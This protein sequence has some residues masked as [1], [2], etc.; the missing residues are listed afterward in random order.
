MSGKERARGCVRF[1]W[2]KILA[3][4][5][6]TARWME[7]VVVFPSWTVFA[8]LLLALSPAFWRVPGLE[9]VGRAFKGLF[10]VV[11]VLVVSVVSAA[12]VWH[13]SVECVFCLREDVVF[14]PPLHALYFDGGGL[15]L[16]FRCGVLVV[17]CNLYMFL[18][19]LASGFSGFGSRALLGHGS[20]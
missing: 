15:A 9:A 7:W 11:L 12:C 8:V 4:T 5:M 6:R 3:T 17:S 10:G 18:C 16:G 2:T 20:M 19:S 13:L 14:S 1:R